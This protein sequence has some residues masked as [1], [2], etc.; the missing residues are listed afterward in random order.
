MTVLLTVFCFFWMSKFV[1]S[2]SEQENV[3]HNAGGVS[4]ND[5]QRQH[6]LHLRQVGR[7]FAQIAGEVRLPKSTVKSF[8]YRHHDAALKA[9]PA[10]RIPAC[11]QCGQS[12][13]CYTCSA[14]IAGHTA[15]MALITER[16]AWY[17]RS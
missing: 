14:S 17:L 12:L 10:T 6:I 4:V 16:N 7:S 1:L 2:L 9:E 13:F 5:I 3:N 11:S 15:S 8:C